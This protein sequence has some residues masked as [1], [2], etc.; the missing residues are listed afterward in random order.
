[1][2]DGKS[3]IWEGA[4]AGRSGHVVS[5]PDWCQKDPGS[6]LTASGCVYLDGRCDV[7]PWAWATHLWS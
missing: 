7:Q 2:M 4:S 1:M 6:N 5:A 3:R